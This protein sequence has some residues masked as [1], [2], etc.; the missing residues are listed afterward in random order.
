MDV[1]EIKAPQGSMRLETFPT[2]EDFTPLLR[3]EYDWGKMNSEQK[4][5]YYF[6]Q[7][8]RI[9]RQQCQCIRA[10]MRQHR[11]QNGHNRK[12]I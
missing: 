4:E 10:F 11:K 3:I 12:A 7:R 9:I 1:M 6:K 5:D 2:F 8:K